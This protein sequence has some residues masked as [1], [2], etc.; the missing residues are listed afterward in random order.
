MIPGVWQGPGQEATPGP[1]GVN[2]GLLWITHTPFQVGCMLQSLG[3]RA[4]VP[5]RLP[6]TP[7]WCGR[8]GG[9]VQEA[10]RG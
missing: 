10:E 4:W 6:S 2:P 1:A 8:L 7:G 5:Q 3:P 9:E